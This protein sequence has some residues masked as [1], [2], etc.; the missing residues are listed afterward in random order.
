ML[1]RNAV[2]LAEN[3]VVW[4]EN[5]VVW[6]AVVLIPLL[7][8]KTRPEAEV[9]SLKNLLFS[10]LFFSLFLQSIISSVEIRIYIL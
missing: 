7:D 3:A 10:R 4:A 2:V 6:D 8:R 1:N 9:F 5:A